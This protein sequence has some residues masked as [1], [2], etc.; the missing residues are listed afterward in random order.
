VDLQFYRKFYPDLHDFSEKELVAHW[1]MSGKLDGRYPDW[2]TYLA[3]DPDFASAIPSEFNPTI[4]RYL[5]SDVDAKF[6]CDWEIISH[7]VHYGQEEGRRFH[8]KD[9]FLFDHQ[10]YSQFLPSDLTKLEAFNHYRT[11]GWK[12]GH[13]PSAYF[14][15]QWYIDKNLQG[16][17]DR[18]PLR[19]C[20][21]SGIQDGLAPFPLFNSRWYAETYLDGK[22]EAGASL[23][24]YFEFGRKHNF[25]PHPLFWS[26]WY[27]DKYLQAYPTIDSL[28]HYLSEGRK[29]DLF[30]NPLFDPA[31]YKREAALETDS[32]PILHY[33]DGGHTQNDPHSLFHSD[34]FWE[35]SVDGIIDKSVN[36]LE[37]YFTSHGHVN[38]CRLLDVAF[39]IENAK[40]AGLDTGHSLPLV[41]YVEL[42]PKGQIDPHPFFS[43]RYYLDNAQDVLVAKVEPLTHYCSGGWSEGRRPHPLFDPE[44]YHR[45]N[46]ASA[47]EN[48]LLHYLRVGYINGA[49]PRGPVAPDQSVKQLPSGRI[50]LEIPRE[51]VLMPGAALLNCRIGAFVHVFYPELAQSVLQ[52]VNNIPGDCTVYIS[53]TSA[54]KA[55]EIATVCD[56]VLSHPYEIR[57][58]PNRGRDIAPMLTG[59]R[60]ALAKCEVGVHI[61]TKKSTHYGQDFTAWREYLLRGNLGTATLIRNI[62]SLLAMP[63]IGAVAPD[64]YAPVEN[65]IQWGGNFAALRDLLWLVGEKLTPEHI[66]DLPTGSM[67]WF[68]TAALQTLIDL[69][70]RPYHFEPEAGQVDGTLAH[71]IE[72]GFFNF[73]EAAGYEWIV[74]RP[75]AAGSGPKQLTSTDTNFISNRVFPTQRD[76]GFVARYYGEC[77]RFTIRPSRITK[78]RLN[79]LIPTVETSKAYAGVATALDIFHSVCRHLGEEFDARM[80]STD[81]SPSNYFSPPADYVMSR[82]L[83]ADLPGTRTVVD[84]A[85]RDRFPVFFRNN[86]IFVATAWWTASHAFQLMDEQNV[87]FGSQQRKM[88]YLIQDFECGFYPWSTKYAL[89]EQTYRA[90][91]RTI[92]VFNT[93]ILRDFFIAENYYSEGLTLLPPIAADILSNIQRDTPKERI[94]VIYARPHAERNCLPFLDMLVGELIASNPRFWDGWRFLAIGEDFPSSD[95]RCTNR[96]EILGRLSL[97]A[98]GETISRAALGLSVMVSPH[99]SYPPLEMAYAGVLTLTNRYGKKDLA[100]LHD[101]VVSF[102]DYDLLTLVKQVTQIAEHWIKQPNI[103]W[104]GKSK[105]GW[106]FDGLSNLEIVAQDLA[107]QVRQLAAIQDIGTSNS[108]QPLQSKHTRKMRRAR[109]TK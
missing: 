95:L 59:F 73:V 77:A 22:H 62:L 85:R 28:E 70:L 35:A 101:N 57:V 107:R 104:T 106:F 94:V 40:K 89:A 102:S 78:P 31:W 80:L 75:P 108:R 63:K 74:S 65:L 51:E 97:Q 15:V 34:Y 21:V 7:F 46:P 50:V 49:A 16:T 12:R 18:D 76:L 81:I 45:Q 96:I 90:P 66:L 8:I 30:P 60:D 83:E 27:K 53:T 4:Y 93:Q 3:N 24:H 92:P 6:D 100:S 26:Q 38:P 9:L 71:A 82:P 58:V 61:H 87:L 39:F 48:P 29:E 32:D 54:I 68:K 1:Q 72:R 2:Q 88:V 20:L 105:V 44:Y 98:Y 11:S 67:F 43:C 19:H 14:N 109:R 23:W 84:A 86:D 13:S 37:R 42:N 5:N 36:A 69:D 47:R 10:W 33:I 91:E 56:Q 103:G 99:P 25:K 17:L 64:H 55:R 79:L 41:S 52:Y